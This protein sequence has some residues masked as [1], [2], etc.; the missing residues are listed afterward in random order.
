MARRAFLHVGTPKSGTSYLQ[1]LWWHHHDELRT[2]GLLLPGSA[3]RDH[4]HAASVVCDRTEVVER[5]GETERRAWDLAVEEIERWQGDALISH[6]LF[7]P[8][9]AQRARG[10][11]QDLQR[12]ADEVHLVVTARDLAR[13]LRSDWQQNVKQ[14]RADTLVEFWERVRDDAS[15]WWL[16][17]D[18]PGLLDR[19]ADGM[20]A[21]R[22]HVV[23][24]PPEGLADRGWLW[25]A[26]CDLLGLDVTGLDDDVHRGNESLGVVEIEVLRR[27][28]SALPGSAHGLDMRRLTKSYFANR[29]LA[30][31]GTGEPFTLPPSLHAWARERGSAMA[32]DL[33]RRGCHVVGDLDHLVSPPEPAGGRTPAEVLDSEVADVAVGALARMLQLEQ[34][35]RTD[36]SGGAG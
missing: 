32:G 24:L 17:Q 29:V 19:W 9:P 7:A 18:V 22:I 12:A 10:A 36:R 28:Q 13:Q 4:F 31:V 23:V 11:V 30:R 15:G 5:L 8:A 1:S 34:R 6:E 2:Q 16:Y 3:L 26:V 33:R 35:R 21:E 14:G 20:P 27:V 25:R